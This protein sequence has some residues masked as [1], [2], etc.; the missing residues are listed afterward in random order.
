MLPWA[1]CLQGVT[2]FFR[3]AVVAMLVQ[4]AM[5][6]AF[7]TAVAEWN[8]RADAVGSLMVVGKIRERSGRVEGFCDTQT[9]VD[10]EFQTCT[11]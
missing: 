8:G 5:L 10:E 4:G 1:R 2:S 9:M 7:D 6:V 3:E 11:L